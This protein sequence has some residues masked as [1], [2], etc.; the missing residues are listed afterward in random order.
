MILNLD[1]LSTA[2]TQSWLQ[3]AIAPRPIALVST[4]DKS[5]RSN[6]APFSFFNMVSSHPPL[7]VFSPSRRV[8]DNTTKHTLDNLYEVPEAVVHVVT[9]DMVQQVS[10]ASC[11]YPK[12]VDEFNK[13]GFTKE[14]ALQVKPFMVKESPI[15]M[16]CRVKEIKPLGKQGGSGNIIIAEV[17]CLHVSDEV[18]NDDG[19]MI[20]QTKLE[21]VARLGGDWYCRVNNKSL[22]KVAKPNTHLG[23]GLDAL[24]YSVAS[25][26]V[27]TGNNLAQLAN[28][29]AVPAKDPSFYDGDVTAI[30]SDYKGHDATRKIHSYTKQLLENNEV[31]K[32]WQV[33]L[34]QQANTAEERTTNL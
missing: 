28:V 8:R 5:G 3:H 9:Y 29:S 19:A 2:A 27:L 24:P 30:L 33:L 31:D 26:T 17:L 7:I 18:L 12:D 6:L 11:D 4:I 14:P 22:F 16:E 25:S 20:D 21:H 13:V 34:M 32:A 23:I 15:K 1:G 10:L